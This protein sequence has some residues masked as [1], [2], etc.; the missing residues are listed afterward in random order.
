MSIG[1]RKEWEEGFRR[2]ASKNGRSYK[3]IFGG[4]GYFAEQKEKRERL[5]ESRN[6]RNRTEES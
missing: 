6:T 5:N 4:M 1:T 3:V 2:F